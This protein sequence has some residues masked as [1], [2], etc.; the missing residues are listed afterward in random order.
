MRF[1][2]KVFL[3]GLGFRKLHAGSG[4]LSQRYSGWKTYWVDAA[5]VPEFLGKHGVELAAGT[6]Y[7]R[8]PML[9]QYQAA[10]IQNLAVRVHG[11]AEG[12]YRISLVVPDR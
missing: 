6:D 3:S 8:D 4:A 7:D 10:A 9:G 2:D 11:Q 5:S 12:R 1:G